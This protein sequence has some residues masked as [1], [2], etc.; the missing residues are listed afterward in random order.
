MLV[1]KLLDVR[2]V[3]GIHGSCLGRACGEDGGRGGGE[4][5]GECV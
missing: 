4:G 5:V 2:A 3:W 1:L